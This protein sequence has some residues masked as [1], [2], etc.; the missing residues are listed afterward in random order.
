[1]AECAARFI[2]LASMLC[3]SCIALACGDDGT[4]APRFHDRGAAGA[5]GSGPAGSKP[6]SPPNVRYPREGSSEKFLLSQTGLYRDLAKKELAPDLI[7]FEPAYKLWSDGAQKQRWLRLPAGSEID[8]SDMDHWVFPVGTMLWKEFSLE[9]RRLET[10]LVARLGPEPDDYF[11]GAFVWADDESDARFMPDG[12]PNVRG[13][14]HD[15]PQTKR[16]FTCH[17]G[18]R[19]R[20]LGYSA[21]QQPAPEAPLSDP[22]DEAYVVP[23]DDVARE[24]LGYL[25]AN[26]GNCHNAEG[27][28]RPDTDLDLRLRVS[29]HT[30]EETSMYATSAGV[31]LQSFE[32]TQLSLRIAPGDPDQSALLFRMLQRGPKTQMP[33]FASEKVDAAGAERVRAFIASMPLAFQP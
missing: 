23:G 33:P 4:D 31:K 7:A 12:E 28:A 29:Q 25:H 5:T 24:A 8:T 16:C 17:N 22:P 11:M 10:R 1:M 21:V 2:R 9:G 20:V 13:T 19:G 18:D 3:C 6:W 30:V 27:S 15:A 26:C 14:E 32:G